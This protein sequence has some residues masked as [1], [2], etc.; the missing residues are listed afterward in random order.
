MVTSSD[1]RCSHLIG[2][3]GHPV[4]FVCSLP[5]CFVSKVTE[6]CLCYLANVNL[7]HHAVISGRTQRINRCHL[8]VMTAYN[9]VC[10]L[11]YNVHVLNKLSPVNLIQSRIF[12]TFEAPG[13]LSPPHRKISKL[14]YY[15][16][17]YHVVHFAVFH[18]FESR[19]S[20][21]YNDF[22]I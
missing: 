9:D 3:L 20:P 12:E 4:D 22:K 11:L 2:Q 16:L 21:F 15:F 8:A 14:L 1:S 18:F 7:A 10:I 19:F 17:S 6:K 5:L 13:G